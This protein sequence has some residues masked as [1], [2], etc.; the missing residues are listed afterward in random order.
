CVDA[1]VAHLVS[2]VGVQLRRDSDGP[3]PPSPVGPEAPGRSRLEVRVSESLTTLR[4]RAGMW[5]LIAAEAAIFTIF[6]VAYLFYVGKSVAD[7]K[8]ADVLHAPI[9]LT[10]CLLSSSLTVHAGVKALQK[11]SVT[12]FARWWL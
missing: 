8:P 2:T 9:F 1:R 5:C 6:V 10:I 3:E 11:G 4:G 12:G 7:P